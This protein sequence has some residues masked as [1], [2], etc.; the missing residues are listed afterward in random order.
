MSSV[1]FYEFL[2]NKIL[3]YLPSSSYKQVAKSAALQ[4][5]YFLPLT[6][7]TLI[8]MADII[9]KK[10]LHAVNELGNGARTR[11]RKGRTE[12]H[13]ACYFMHLMTESM[14]MRCQ[15]H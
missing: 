10:T 14:S 9:S 8:R 15:I 2:A 3:H 1:I 5:L 12:Q 13:A 11:R 7:M 6:G 4:E